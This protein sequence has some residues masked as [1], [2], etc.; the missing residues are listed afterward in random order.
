MNKNAIDIQISNESIKLSEMNKGLL[1]LK[2]KRDKQ[3]E[4]VEKTLKNIKI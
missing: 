1:L 4:A 3:R 2:I